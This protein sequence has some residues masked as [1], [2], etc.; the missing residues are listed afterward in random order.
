MYKYTFDFGF[1][2]NDGCDYQEMSVEINSPVSL[3]NLVSSNGVNEDVL[4]ARLLVECSHCYNP[5]SVN[6]CFLR[7]QT[8][9]EEQGS[10]APAPEDNF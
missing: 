8:L 2:D 10:T 1:T 5:Y 9:K 6:L 4:I 3:H 7:V